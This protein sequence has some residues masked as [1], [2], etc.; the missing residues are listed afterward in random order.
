[1]YVDTSISSL[2]LTFTLLISEKY[3]SRSF[4][5]QSSFSAWTSFFQIC[6]IL[7]TFIEYNWIKVNY[8]KNAF[9]QDAYRPLQWPSRGGGCLPKGVVCP[10]ECLSRGCLPGGVCPGVGGCLPGGYLPRG[11][12]GQWSV[13]PG[14]VCSGRGGLPQCMLGYTPPVN[15][16]T[17]DCEKWK[18]NL[19][20]TTLQMVTR[21]HCSRMCTVCC[22]SHLRG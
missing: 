21:I 8:N 22:S 18:H 2:P 4:W 17:D 20:A 19:A 7:Y 5:I 6:Q 11:V 14:N 3:H 16:M 10:G 1:M 9:Q 15:R 13:C 12:S